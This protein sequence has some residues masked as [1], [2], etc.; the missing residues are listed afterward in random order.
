MVEQDPRVIE[1]REGFGNLSGILHICKGA[2]QLDRAPYH[3]IDPTQHFE[4]L[5]YLV[6]K[7]ARKEARDFAGAS[8][9]HFCLGAFANN[10]TRKMGRYEHIWAVQSDMIRQT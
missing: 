6:E 10:V 5:K 3:F 2:Q 9:L 1:K 4:C 8:A 7:G